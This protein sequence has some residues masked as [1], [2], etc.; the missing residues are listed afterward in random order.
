MAENQASDANSVLRI[1]PLDESSLIACQRMVRSRN[2]EYAD[3]MCAIASIRAAFSCMTP[4]FRGGN[5]N[6]TS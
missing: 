3:S 2:L 1:L 6:G 5:P 4:F